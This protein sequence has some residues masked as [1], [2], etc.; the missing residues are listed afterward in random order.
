MVTIESLKVGGQQHQTQNPFFFV[1]CLLHILRLD[2]PELITDTGVQAQ[3]LIRSFK[4]ASEDLANLQGILCGPPPVIANGGFISTNRK[5]FPYRTVVTYRCNLGERGINLFDLVGEPSIYC[6]SKDNQVGIWSGPP[7][8][9][10]INKCT[11]PEV[12]NGI[13]ISENRS[14]FFLHEMVRFTCQP[15]FTMK[16]PSTVQCQAPNQW[17]PELPSCSR[18][19]S[20]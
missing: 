18:G 15:G 20:D 7:P 19:E 2:L 10:I 17:V 9:C 6:T 3:R 5:Y 13:R 1:L 14:L 12:E 16:G 4:D 8:R 11:P